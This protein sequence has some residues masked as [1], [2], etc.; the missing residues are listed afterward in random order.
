MSRVQFRGVRSAKNGVLRLCRFLAFR[1]ISRLKDSGGNAE[2]EMGCQTAGTARMYMF[3]AS[4]YQPH[5]M[6]LLPERK[7]LWGCPLTKQ[8]TTPELR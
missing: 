8:S 3:L 7:G 5:A 4:L 6:C 2:F 1:H